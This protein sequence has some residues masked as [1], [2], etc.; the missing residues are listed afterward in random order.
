MQ[1]AFPEDLINAA[2]NQHHLTRDEI[3]ILDDY[4]LVRLLNNDAQA[5][6]RSLSADDFYKIAGEELKQKVAEI[7]KQASPPVTNIVFDAFMPTIDDCMNELSEYFPGFDSKIRFSSA[8][9]NEKIPFNQ[10]GN[11]ECEGVILNTEQLAKINNIVILH[12]NDLKCVGKLIQAAHDLKFFKFISRILLMHPYQLPV[13]TVSR[14][15]KGL[16]F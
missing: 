8:M 15:L 4:W 3:H 6:D 14:N 2:I 12:C 13:Q 9:F 10:D 1:P 5:I 11:L 16:K 7:I